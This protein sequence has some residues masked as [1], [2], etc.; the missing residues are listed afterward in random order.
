MLF[1][2]HL[3]AHLRHVFLTANTLITVR[4]ALD[5]PS[6]STDDHLSFQG[7]DAEVAESARACSYYPISRCRLLAGQFVWANLAVPVCII[8]LWV[9]FL[10]SLRVFWSLTPRRRC[11][12]SGFRAGWPAPLLP[13]SW[14]CGGVVT[15]PLEVPRL[16]AFWHHADN[17]GGGTDT[18]Q[19][20]QE[21][22]GYHENP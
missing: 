5:L 13:L 20:S 1:R 18:H 12:L 11:A 3:P 14:I 10:V 19:I 8:V 15:M 2:C 7:V 6:L 22:L 16:L 4:Q 21:T 17:L 9:R